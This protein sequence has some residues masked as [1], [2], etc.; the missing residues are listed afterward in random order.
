[1]TT[2]DLNDHVFGKPREFLCLTVAILLHAPLIWWQASPYEPTQGDPITGVDFIIEEEPKD[3]PPPP[4]K[5]VEPVAKPSFF[6]KVQKS[7]GLATPKPVSIQK[8]VDSTPKPTQL[9]GTT[10]AGPIS[11]SKRIESILGSDKLTDK[12]RTPGSPLAGTLAVS[13][14]KSQASL[15]PG[16]IGAGP[17]KAGGGTL[18]NKSQGSF[19]LG[20]KDLPFNVARNP[21]GD[22]PA[23]MEDAPRIAVAGGRSS[24]S[25][26]RISTESFGTGGG[27]GG[28]TGSGDGS[29]GGGGAL[30]D[31]GGGVGTGLSGVGGDFDGIPS[32]SSGG[33]GRQSGTLSGVGS[34]GGGGTGAGSGGKTP[35]EITGRLSGRKIIYLQMP[36][37]PDWAREKAIIARVVLHFVVTHDG[38][39]KS[40]VT[41]VKET[42]GYKKLDDAAV[43]ALADWHFEPLPASQYGQEQDGFIIFKFR[44][45]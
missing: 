8:L 27:T 28:G 20:A 42:S 35:F 4:V 44:A 10:S 40:N 22:L 19:K 36:P 6:E 9:A 23:G 5:V 34:G 24:K 43:K 29:G 13:N 30:T 45:L 1:M 7:L 33:G 41:T 14:I 12:T 16:G 26:R 21:A 37:Y 18:Q 38:V 3:E 17:I 31:K 32:D 2:L 25:I 15:A 11:T 39:V